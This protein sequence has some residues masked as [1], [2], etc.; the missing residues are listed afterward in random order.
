M[1]KT[2]AD[3]RYRLQRHNMGVLASHI[4]EDRLFVREL[5]QPYDKLDIKLGIS[6]LLWGPVTSVKGLVMRKTFPCHGVVMIP[7]WVVSYSKKYIST[8]NSCES[9]RFYSMMFSSMRWAWNVV[10]V[11]LTFLT[12]IICTCLRSGFGIGCPHYV[13]C[14]GLIFFLTLVHVFWKVYLNSSWS[15]RLASWIVNLYCSW[16]HICFICYMSMA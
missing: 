12:R 4:L 11:D 8:E 16:Y 9:N 10:A 2:T 15:Q 5:E 6:D 7:G 14:R 13:W 1:F 3:G